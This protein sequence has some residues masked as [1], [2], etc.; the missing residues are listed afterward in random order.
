M[1]ENPHE[2]F[3][4]ALRQIGVK[5]QAVIRIEQALVGNSQKALSK[6][7]SNAL[8]LNFSCLNLV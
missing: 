7:S 4:G 5:E 2:G 6:A 3:P 8:A 1:L